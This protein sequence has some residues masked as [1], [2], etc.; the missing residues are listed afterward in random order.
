MKL[1]LVVCIKARLN[2]F[3]VAMVPT[4]GTRWQVYMRETGP[5]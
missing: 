1:Y 5:V 2:A 4:E 3:V